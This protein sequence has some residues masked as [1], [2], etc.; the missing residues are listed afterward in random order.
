M[1]SL[2]QILKD[3]RLG[4]RLSLTDLE[5][6]TKIKRSFLE[7]LEKQNWQDLP[8]YPVVNGFV[9]SIASFL[10]VDPDKAVALLR[11]DYPQKALRISPKPDLENKFVWSPRLTFFLGIALLLLSL[12]GYLTI[13]YSKF[14]RPPSLEVDLPVQNEVEKKTTVK[15]TG[16]TNPE[17]SVE[18]NDQPVIV[19]D[20]GDFSTDLLIT[21]TTTDIR[22][23]AKS[24]SGKTTLVDR[25]I[26]PQIP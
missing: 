6:S 13:Q 14:V 22:V 21:K 7:N 16:K 8:E 24:R 2:G 4:K 9:K 1:I 12:F 5:K 11:R 25:K 10:E 17:A 23:V 18:V 20:S 19:M 3:A 15:V 26:V